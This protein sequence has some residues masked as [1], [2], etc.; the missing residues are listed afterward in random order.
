MPSVARRHGVSVECCAELCAADPKCQGFHVFEPCGTSDCYA[1]HHIDKKSTFIPLPSSYGFTWKGAHPPARHN[2]SASCASPSWNAGFPFTWKCKVA[3]VSRALGPSPAVLTPLPGL[4]KTTTWSLGSSRVTSNGTGWSEVGNFTTTDAAK[5]QKWDSVAITKLSVATM[6]FTIGAKGSLTSVECQITLNE[7]SRMVITAK[8]LLFGGS[9]G[10]MLTVNGTAKT[11]MS[12]PVLTKTEFNNERYGKAFAGIKV[13]TPP[14]KF[15]VIDG[16]IAGDDD[17][18]NWAFCVGGLGS[19]GINGIGT[20]PDNTFDPRLLEVNRIPFTKGGEYAP[21]GAEPDTGLTLNT[22]YMEAWAAHQLT[23][24]Y[25]AGFKPEQLGAFALA[26]EPG[27]SF[28]RSTPEHL[29]N[30]SRGAPAAALEKEWRAFLA[31]NKV[32][33]LSMPSTKRWQL[34]TL[35]AKKLFYWSSRFSAYSSAAAFARATAA[36]EGATAKGARIYT[37]LNNF[38]GRCYVPGYP[39]STDPNAGSL[40]LDWFEFGREPAAAPCCGR[41][42]G[43]GTGKRVSGVTTALGCARPPG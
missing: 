16:C 2:I 36:I 10:L 27:W 5:A 40:S 20:D 3:G 24:F 28:P 15:P 8:G 39:T 6:P 19:L 38:A 13:A 32:T 33:G 21:P 22:S 41:R 7:S 43:L 29:M 25:A 37:N 17:W 34:K 31:K 1:Y 18:Y 26:D 14:K 35:A 9:L 23:A 12:V 42:T 11:K 4:P 30:A